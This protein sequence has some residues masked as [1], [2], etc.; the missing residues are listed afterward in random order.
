[1]KKNNFLEIKKK[2]IEH[3]DLKINKNINKIN[4]IFNLSRKIF[5][6]IIFCIGIY[7][8]INLV[9][10]FSNTKINFQKQKNINYILDNF[11]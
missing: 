11:K 9:N 4:N 7:M 1:M 2:D 8:I 10:L 5:I 3:I 6:F